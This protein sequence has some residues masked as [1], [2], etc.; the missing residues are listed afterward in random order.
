V[1]D[2]IRYN[3]SDGSLIRVTTPLAHGEQIE[4]AR[5]RLL[6]FVGLVTPQLARYIPQ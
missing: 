3:R 1:E 2:A 6:Q 5:Q 4:S